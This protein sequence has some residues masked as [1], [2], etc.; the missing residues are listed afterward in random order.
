MFSSSSSSVTYPPS[1]RAT[2]GDLQGWKCDQNF[3]LL[4]DFSVP[5]YHHAGS[6]NGVI[7]C[8]MALCSGPI[9]RVAPSSP[10]LPGSC[11]W[12]LQ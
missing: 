1:P 12:S 4:A 5:E 11:T 3:S 2:T 8:R 6:R 9:V 10:R 7:R